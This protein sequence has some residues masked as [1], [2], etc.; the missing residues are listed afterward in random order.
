MANTKA[1]SEEKIVSSR[2][3]KFPK[4]V[5]MNDP[6]AKLITSF[7]DKDLKEEFSTFLQSRMAEVVPITKAKSAK[8]K[9][10]KYKQPGIEPMSF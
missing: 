2:V 10:G 5:S 3:A 1:V 6:F 7:F 9:R 8:E 4:K